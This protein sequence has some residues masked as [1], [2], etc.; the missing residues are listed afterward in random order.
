MRLLL[1]LS[2]LVSAHLLGAQSSATGSSSS[3]PD[4]P[5]ARWSSVTSLHSGTNV[6]VN[7]GFHSTRCKFQQATDQDLTCDAHGSRKFAAGE[8]RTVSTSNRA[9]SAAVFGAIGAGVGVLV[10][11]IVDSTLFGNVSRGTVKGSVYAGGAGLGALVFAPIGYAKGFM[12]RTV[13]R[14]P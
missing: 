14:A 7:T 12:H 10:V 1:V 5:N 13:Y 9:E 8:I 4:A 6:W 2:L 11:K 3:L